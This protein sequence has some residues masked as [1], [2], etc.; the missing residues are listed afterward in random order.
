MSLSDIPEGS[1]VLID[2]SIFLYAITAAPTGVA[3][4][5]STE[6]YW[7]LDRCRTRAVLGIIST[8]TLTRLWK[9]LEAIAVLKNG[10]SR[11]TAKR[12][13]L[14]CGVPADAPQLNFAARIVELAAT[15]LVILTIQREDFAR[16]GELSSGLLFDIDSALTVAAVEREYNDTFCVATATSN[17]DALVG[18][19]RSEFLSLYRPSDV[20]RL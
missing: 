2:P 20:E 15:N 16:A 8:A 5:R 13:A 10:D 3:E 19:R 18:S 4:A 17:F 14:I 11:D 12:Q 1:R 6:C 7:L 9:Q